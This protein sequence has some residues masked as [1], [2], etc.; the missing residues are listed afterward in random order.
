MRGRGTGVQVKTRGGECYYHRDM[1][2]SWS[3]KKVMPT[4]SADLGYEHLDEV[5]EGGGAQLALLELR[6]GG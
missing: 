6:S 1:K 3:I 2:G 5:K 4:I